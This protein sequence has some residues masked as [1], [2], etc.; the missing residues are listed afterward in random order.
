MVGSSLKILYFQFPW[1]YFGSYQTVLIKI[2]MVIVSPFPFWRSQNLEVCLS[3]GMGK[4]T[5]PVVKVSSYGYHK[6]KKWL[7]NSA[8]SRNRDKSLFLVVW[9]Y[10]LLDLKCPHCISQPS[11]VTHFK[12]PPNHGR[13]SK[14][15]YI[16]TVHHIAFSSHL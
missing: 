9:V 2:D 16:W 15:T 13:L 11:E 7:L 12:I 4:I 5:F 1:S 14:V 6:C 10:L 8:F 3:D